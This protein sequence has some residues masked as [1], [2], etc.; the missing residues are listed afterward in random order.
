[1]SEKMDRA[2]VSPAVPKQEWTINVPVLSSAK[3]HDLSLSARVCPVFRS[4]D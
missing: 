1:M 2:A 3:F 4:N